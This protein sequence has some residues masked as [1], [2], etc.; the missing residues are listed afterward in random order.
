VIHGFFD[1]GSEFVQMDYGEAID[2]LERANE[3]SNPRSS[4]VIDLQSEPLPPP[5]GHRRLVVFSTKAETH[6]GRRYRRSP[7]RHTHNE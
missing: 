7:L 5:C 3:N 2:V 6:L 1:I 4:Q